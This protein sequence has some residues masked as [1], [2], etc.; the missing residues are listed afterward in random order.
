VIR[1]ERPHPRFRASYLGAYVQE[2]LE[3]EHTP[4]PHFVR[5]LVFWA[6]VDDEVVGRVSL[7]L[8]LN[9]FL[10]RIGG[11]IGYIVRP[12]WRGKGVA[13]EMLRLMLQT[14]Q[15]RAIGRLLLTC[16]EHNTASKRTILKN[17]G[18]LESV[19]DGAPGKPRKNRF[20][21]L[22]E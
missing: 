21:I 8:E 17:G 13:T 9:E 2:L 7:R 3:R 1:L 12:S 10:S 11:H 6:A 18:I 19:V 22:L 20:W 4:P 15:A 5:D 16:D 14:P